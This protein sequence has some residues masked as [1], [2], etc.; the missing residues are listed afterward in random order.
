MICLNTMWDNSICS[1]LILYFKF[2]YHVNKDT[3]SYMQKYAAAILWLAER[4]WNYNLL[5][6]IA[7]K[8]HAVF[9]ILYQRTVDT[10][11]LIKYLRTIGKKKPFKWFSYYITIQLSVHVVNNCS[12][13]T[14]YLNHILICS[15]IMYTKYVYKLYTFAVRGFEFLHE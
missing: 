2:Y 6:Y 11:D 10:T 12:N 5:V 8:I 14:E 13:W 4:I 9:N 7:E 15:L 3:S 1:I